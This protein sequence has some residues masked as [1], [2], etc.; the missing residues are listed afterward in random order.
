MSRE[1]KQPVATDAGA[2]LRDGHVHLADVGA[3][4]ARRLDEVGPV[5]E[6]E[7]RVVGGAA[8]REPLGGAEDLRVGGALAPQL[9]GVDTPAQCR[10]EKGVGPVVA[11]EVEV[12]GA[13]PRAT[14]AHDGDRA[15]TS[16]DEALGCLLPGALRWAERAETDPPTG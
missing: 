9:D 5:V 13:Q 10:L 15:S 2:R 1:T 11:D 4:G 14:V 7:Q 3:V 8:A 12:G 6:D 16:G